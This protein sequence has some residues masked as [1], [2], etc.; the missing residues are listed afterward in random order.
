M[1]PVKM[2]AIGIKRNYALNEKIELKHIE[3]AC[4]DLIFAGWHHFTKC[5]VGAEF[6]RAT[7]QREIKAFLFAINVCE[8]NQCGLCGIR[9]CVNIIAF[10]LISICAVLVWHIQ[11][12]SQ[13]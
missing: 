8:R 5:K 3:R 7:I 9:M 2:N 10:T 4:C 12:F 6:K 1:L 13:N 11:E